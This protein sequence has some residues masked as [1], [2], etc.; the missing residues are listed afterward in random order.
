MH[1][2]RIIFIL[3]LI[4][5]LIPFSGFTPGTKKFLIIL[6]GV[7]V[8]TVAFLIERRITLS[9]HW[10]KSHGGAP[11]AETYAEHNGSTPKSVKMDIEAVYQNN[12]SPVL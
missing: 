7:V 6:F 9:L 8:M 12:N 11:R 1:K 10:R 5:A 4:I 2:N 3:G